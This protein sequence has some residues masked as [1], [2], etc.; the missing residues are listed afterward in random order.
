MAETLQ[1][2]AVQSHCCAHDTS[3]EV[4]TAAAQAHRHT[5]DCQVSTETDMFWG[6]QAHRRLPL[7]QV[8]TKT[9]MFYCLSPQAHRHTG[10][11]TAAAGRPSPLHNGGQ[12]N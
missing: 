3:P 10:A 1:R 12:L 4:R 9:D 7:S 6:T 11:Q 5:D 2:N 8:S